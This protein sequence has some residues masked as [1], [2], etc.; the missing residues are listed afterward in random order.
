MHV[1]TRKALQDAAERHPEWAS[2]LEYWYRI[3]KKAEIRDFAS[4]KKLFNSVDKVG[5]RYVFNVGDNK[6][7]VIAAIHFNRRRIYIRS[8]LA[9]VEYDQDKWK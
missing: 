9:H 7:R 1:I 2:A 6:I 5:D 4:L 8:V 3:V